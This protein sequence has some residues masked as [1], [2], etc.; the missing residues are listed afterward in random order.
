MPRSV[1]LGLPTSPAARR[2]WSA[3]LAVAVC[4]GVAACSGDDGSASPTAGPSGSATEV[5]APADAVTNGI[6]EVGPEQALELALDALLDATSY[7]VSGAPTAG[8]PLDLVFVAGQDPS[9]PALS[10][11]QPSP[12]GAPSAAPSPSATDAVEPEAVGRGSQGFVSQDGSTFDL[13]V[14]DGDAYVRGNLDWLAAAVDAE[15]RRTLG[16]K[17][18]L[19]PES[20]AQT[21]APFT[22]PELFATAALTTDGSVQTVGVSLIDGSPALGIRFLNSEAT[23]WLAGVGEPHPILIERLGATAADGVLRF[24]DVGADVT[25]QAPPADQVVVAAEPAA[26][27]SG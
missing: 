15:A 19:L 9:T 10:T 16:E 2:V 26:A 6:D 14:V 5:V 22:D 12:S 7:R 1:P 18:L 24:S 23:V 17:W 4:L 11:A 27:D 20:V 8:A 13:L 21:L 3:A 25:L